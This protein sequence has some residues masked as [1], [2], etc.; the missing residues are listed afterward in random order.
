MKAIKIDA[1][2]YYYPSD[3]HSTESFSA[4]L[5]HHFN[6]FIQLVHLK[7]DNCVEPYFIED[8]TEIIYLNISDI[9][10]FQEAEIMVLPKA[11][12]NRRLKE[13]VQRKCTNCAHCGDDDDLQSCARNISLDGECFLFKKA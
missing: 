11:E 6:Q 13:V 1:E 5:N 3:Y 8:D 2:L 7:E 4:Y 12:Y 9:H 10:Q